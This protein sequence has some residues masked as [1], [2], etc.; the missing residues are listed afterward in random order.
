MEVF[1]G[2]I[3]AG[4]LLGIGIMFAGIVLQ[5]ALWAIMIIFGGISYLVAGIVDF[6]K[7]RN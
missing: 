7:R 3:I 2:F 6:V 1:L 4:V 5:A